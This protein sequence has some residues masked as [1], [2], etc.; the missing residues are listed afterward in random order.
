MS[1]KGVPRISSG[2]FYGKYQL[3]FQRIAYFSSK[4][5]KVCDTFLYCDQMLSLA[6]NIPNAVDYSVCSK[7]AYYL[8]RDPFNIVYIWKECPGNNMLT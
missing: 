1:K 3:L 2:I 7:S 6:S 8:F 5:V 4:S